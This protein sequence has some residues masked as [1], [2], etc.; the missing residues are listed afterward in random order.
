MAT[1]QFRRGPEASI[2][3]LVAGEPG[4]T[5]DTHIL[6]VGYGGVNYPVGGWSPVPG[7]SGA[8]G[9]AGQK[10]YDS[11]YLYICVAANTWKRIAFDTFTGEYLLL[12]SGDHILTE[13]GELILLD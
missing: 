11:D 7:S 12:E 1:I 9:K 3:T 6:F 13:A 5:T 2:P 4:W 10:A 8:V